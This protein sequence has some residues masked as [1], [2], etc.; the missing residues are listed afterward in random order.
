M[1]NEYKQE[2]GKEIRR[3]IK[4]PA[5]IEELKDQLK[6]LTQS[7]TNSNLYLISNEQPKKSLFSRIKSIFS[8]NK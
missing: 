8:K 1:V 6:G 7:T 3:T 4:T 5:D 2:T